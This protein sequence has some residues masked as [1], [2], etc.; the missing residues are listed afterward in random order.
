MCPSV[1]LP[2]AVRFRLSAFKSRDCLK[3]RS[4]LPP[5]R[6]TALHPVYSHWLKWENRWWIAL[7]WVMQIVSAAR[8]SSNLGLTTLKSAPWLVSTLAKRTS[9]RCWVILT[10]WLR[11]GLIRAFMARASCSVVAVA[12][13][14]APMPI[15]NWNSWQNQPSF[16]G[17]NRF[18]QPHWGL[19]QPLTLMTWSEMHWITLVWLRLTPK[20]TWPRQCFCLFMSKAWR[21]SIWM[22]KLSPQP[23]WLTK[24]LNS[25]IHN[26]RRSRPCSKVSFV[27]WWRFLRVS[28]TPSP[29][30]W[31]LW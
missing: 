15:A 16:R 8:I 19:R 30:W 20:S 5:W 11:L 3:R 31:P 9:I 27:R 18:C 10:R 1:L 28:F 6:N 25:A 22:I 17:L 7:G 29:L 21:A 13:W 12:I 4:Q 14:T 24:R 23:L 26:G 2:Q